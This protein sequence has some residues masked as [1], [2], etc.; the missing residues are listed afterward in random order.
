MTRK[1][2]DEVKYFRI[3]SVH[4]VADFGL[5]VQFRNGET[6]LYDVKSCFEKWPVFNKL[7][8]HPRNFYDV[9]VDTGGLGVIWD[10]EIDLGCN[11]LYYGGKRVK[12][13]FTGLISASDATKYWGLNEST[14]RKAISY[15][16]L[17]D[18]TDVQ[19]FGKQW[20]V[21]FAAM[22]RVYG[23]PKTELILQQ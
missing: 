21:S 5:L 9:V 14:L 10:D 15:G 19:K 13:P 12:T 16:K 2:T 6:R 8:K 18:G 4:P 3:S 22:K 17:R 1:K 20:V 7:K 11:E 23:D